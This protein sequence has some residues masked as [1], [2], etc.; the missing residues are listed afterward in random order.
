MEILKFS[1]LEFQFESSEYTQKNTIKSTIISLL[2]VIGA[3]AATFTVALNIMP[4]SN[5]SIGKI[6][7][8]A[9]ASI[10]TFAII[11]GI[12]FY[13]SIK[14]T[15]KYLETINWLRKLDKNDLEIGIFNNKILVRNNKAYD[16]KTISQIFNTTAELVES[17]N[18]DR[19]KN[20]YA[21]VKI[22]E[23]KKSR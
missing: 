19:N 8:M 6:L 10:A 21:I 3:F 17:D 20:L 18:I 9:F 5:D 13:V 14:T 11:I 22:T 16:Y 4:D 15:P 12:G 23:D 1:N 7:L 2:F